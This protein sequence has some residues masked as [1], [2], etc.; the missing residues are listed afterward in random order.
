[1]KV[2]IATKHLKVTDALHQ[3]IQEQAEK[4]SKLHKRITLVRVYLETIEKKSNDP[5][6]NQVTFEI[7]IPGKNVV[8]KKQA[9]DMYQAVTA[10]AEASLR[11]L[12]KLYEKRMTLKRQGVPEIAPL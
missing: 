9:A 1:M 4:L 12:R 10:T 11:Q 7:E 3:F 8:V 6:A 2:L 5:H